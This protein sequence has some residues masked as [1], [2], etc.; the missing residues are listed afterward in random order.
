[1]H[2]EVGTRLRDVRVGA[3]DAAA[4]DDVD[5]GSAASA[6]P[7]RVTAAV[8]RGAVLLAYLDA[9][10]RGAP[11]PQLVLDRADIVDRNGVLLASNLITASLY[12]D[13][14]LVFDPV[15]AA[16]RLRTV[17]PHL[18]QTDLIAQLSGDRRFVW[19]QRGLKPEQQ[20]Q[21]VETADRVTTES[22]I[23]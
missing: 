6:D 18:N 21:L 2:E 11:P 9:L 7:V 17:L 1:M 20:Y 14:K 8:R 15:D 12:A 16:T 22:T 10:A 19:I 4:R 13:P 23:Q 5:G 3:V